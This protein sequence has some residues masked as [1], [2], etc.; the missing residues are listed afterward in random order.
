MPLTS[1]ND[2]GMDLNSDD[3]TDDESQPRK[4][5]PAWATGMC[6]GGDVCVQGPQ[7]TVGAAVGFCPAPLAWR[8]LKYSSMK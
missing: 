6:V 8:S 3:S 1:S 7:Q 2:Y 4:P 5:V